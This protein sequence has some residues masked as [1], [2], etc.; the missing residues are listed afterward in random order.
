VF[1]P[2]REESSSIIELERTINRIIGND[3]FDVVDQYDE[4]S[5]ILDILPFP[6]QIILQEPSRLPPGRLIPRQAAFR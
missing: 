5:G 3:F 2:T 4:P 6:D 1:Q